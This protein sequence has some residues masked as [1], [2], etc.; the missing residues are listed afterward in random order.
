M[1]AIR[2]IVAFTLMLQIWFSSV[3]YAINR[4]E[5]LVRG[6]AVVQINDLSEPCLQELHPGKHDCCEKHI[7][8]KS[9]RKIKKKCCGKESTTCNKPTLQKEG[10][11][12]N[13]EQVKDNCCKSTVTD[14]HLENGDYVEL[15]NPLFGSEMS[16]VSLVNNGTFLYQAGD[17][18][19]VVNI[20]EPPLLYCSVTNRLALK[21]VWII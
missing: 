10:N 3:G 11:S 20:A 12:S 4:I 6:D 21:S 16:S 7:S 17:F 2:K 1:K 14:V 13:R 5:C 18:G 9:E 19:I 15:V 8:E